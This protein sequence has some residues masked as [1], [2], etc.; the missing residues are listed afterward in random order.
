M[1]CGQKWKNKRKQRALES[2][3]MQQ[4]R[5]WPE[6]WGLVTSCPARC[7]VHPWL[8]SPDAVYAVCWCQLLSHD[9]RTFISSLEPSGIRFLFFFFFLKNWVSLWGLFFWIS[10]SVG[11]DSISVLWHWHRVYLH[12]RPGVTNPTEEH[13]HCG[14]QGP[15]SRNASAPEDPSTPSLCWTHSSKKPFNTTSNTLGSTQHKIP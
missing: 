5:F 11:S 1:W 9:F 12:R 3:R 13:A 8:L 2:Q 6:P 10:F 14:G 4:S 15:L 7:L